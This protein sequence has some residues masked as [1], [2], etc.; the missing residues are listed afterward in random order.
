MGLPMFK[1]KPNTQ[2]Q[3]KA[4]QSKAKQS[5]AKQTKPNQTKPN[6]TKINTHAKFHIPFPLLLVMQSL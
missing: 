5:K 6:H 3:S 1:I 2:K 4:K